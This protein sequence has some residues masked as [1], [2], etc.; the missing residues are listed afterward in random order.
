MLKYLLYGLLLL[1]FV[2]LSL[3]FLPLTVIS[4][5]ELEFFGDL[6]FMLFVVSFLFVFGVVTINNIDNTKMI[7]GRIVTL[8]VKKEKFDFSK[9][10]IFTFLLLLAVIIFSIVGTQ[11]FFSLDN[12]NKFITAFIVLGGLPV[13]VRTVVIYNIKYLYLFIAIDFFIYFL[14]TK[15]DLISF[16]KMIFFLYGNI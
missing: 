3:A 14:Y 10:K 4:L 16:L 6:F 13:L 8:P 12:D 2:S 15:M 9:N 11:A 7:N 1:V 5:S